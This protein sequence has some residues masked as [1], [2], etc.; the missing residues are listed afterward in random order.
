[1]KQL[2]LFKILTCLALIF[3]TACKADIVSASISAEYPPFIKYEL[4]EEEASR[5]LDYLDTIDTDKYEVAP[6]GIV[7][8]GIFNDIKTGDNK[9]RTLYYLGK[10]IGMEDELYIIED[11]PLIDI[12]EKYFGQLS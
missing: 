8:N 7:G 12:I 9:S 5:V 11:F 3:M 1:M 2:S 4:S 10:Y 6:E